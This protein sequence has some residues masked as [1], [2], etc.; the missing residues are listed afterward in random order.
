[1]L[2]FFVVVLAVSVGLAIFEILVEKDNGW[3][4]G[5]GPFWGEKIFPR[6]TRRSNVRETLFHSLSFGN[7][8]LVAPK[9]V[10]WLAS[11]FQ[12]PDARPHRG[13]ARNLRR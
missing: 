3:G 12:D 5:F 4:T 6:R 9:R 2:T 10:V 8:L 11:H 7:V 13:M 1:M